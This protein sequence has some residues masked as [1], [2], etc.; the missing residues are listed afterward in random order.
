MRLTS[1]QVA[2]VLNCQPHDVPVLVMGRLLKP[3]G[4]PSATWTHKEIRSLAARLVFDGLAAGEANPTPGFQDL[5][6]DIL[7]F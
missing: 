1:E 5:I 2:W 6:T 4:N 7:L 3:L